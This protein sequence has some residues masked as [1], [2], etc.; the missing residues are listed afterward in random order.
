MPNA[1]NDGMKQA[2]A[3]LLLIKPLFILPVSREDGYGGQ[4]I[5][6]SKKDAKDRW[7]DAVNI[8]AT[9]NTPYDEEGIFIT[10]DG[11]TLY[12]SSRGHNTMGG[13]DIFKTEWV[14][15]KWSNPVTSV[16]PSTH[17]KT[18]YFLPWQPAVKGVIIHQR[19]KMDLVDMIYTSLPFWE[20]P[21]PCY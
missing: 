2:S 15:G 19:K 1:I 7:Q 3:A 14:D 4:D 5:Y 16:I 8:G 9:I 10:T 12:F 11:K 21:N 17:R 20:L 13:F 18:M 6:M